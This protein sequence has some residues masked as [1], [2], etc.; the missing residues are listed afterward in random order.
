MYYIIMNPASKSGKG[1]KIWKTIEPVLNKRQIPYQLLTSSYTGHVAELVADITKTDSDVNI[2]IL[3]GDGTIN[4]A[5]QGIRDFSKVKLG[6]IPTGSSND[7]AR[8]MGLGKDPLE[9]LETIL[10]GKIARQMDVGLLTYKNHPDAQ[11]YFVV[12]SGIG[13]DAA[14]CEE[15]LSSRMKDFLNKIKLGKLTYLGIALKQL[16]AARPVACELT[17]D[18]SSPIRVNRFLFVASMIHQYEGGGF[19]FCP[20]ADTEDGMLDICFVG[21]IPKLLILIALPTA[22]FGKHYMFPHISHYRAHTVEI[23]TSAPLWVHTDG[24]V[25]FKDDHINLT[26]EKQKLTFL[27]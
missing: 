21:R 23:K 3:G 20:S 11:R 22:F 15:A 17:L 2:I 12:S 14:V 24:E 9:I 27:V 10:S 8:D 16:I 7:L 25:F 4:E 5:L 1:I 18:D 13:F 19:K 6:Y 26:C